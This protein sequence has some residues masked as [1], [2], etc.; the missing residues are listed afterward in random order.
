[1]SSGFDMT[2]LRHDRDLQ[3]GGLIASRA[4]Q[5]H[6]SCGLSRLVDAPSGGSRRLH[7]QHHAHIGAVLD[8][9]RL[10]AKGT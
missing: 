9:S 6:A 4:G 5:Q 1:M 8:A 3:D 10:H 2:R 7:P